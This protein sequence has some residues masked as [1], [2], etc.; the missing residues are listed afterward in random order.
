MLG[1]VVVSEK[2]RFD[3]ERQFK[4]KP[5]AQTEYACAKAISLSKVAFA[6]SHLMDVTL[7]LLPASKR[8]PK[9]ISKPLKA[10]KKID[11]VTTDFFAFDDTTNHYALQGAGLAVEMG[12][13]TL[14]LTCANLAAKAPAWVAVRNASDSQIDGSLPY[15]KQVEMAG[16]IYEKY[17]YWTTVNSAIACWAVIMS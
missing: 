13:A 16:R 8:H 1:D 17:G 2:V 4:N 5:F 6:S 9:I 15:N 14:G 3:C 10:G 11:V 12:D 7:S